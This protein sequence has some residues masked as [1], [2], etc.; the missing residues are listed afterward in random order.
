MNNHYN[1]D[2]KDYASELRTCAISKAEKYLWKAGLS[3]NQMGV[4]FKRQRPIYNFIVD[5][6]S[7][8]IGLIVEVDG[9]SHFT[10]GEYDAYRQKKLEELGYTV[11]RF[12]EGEVMNN[13]PSVDDK[14]R[15]AIYCLKNGD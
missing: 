2:L 10:K 14:I 13:Y 15:H 1:K 5:F 3:R 8:E 11:L 4:K 6:F 9:N 12:N 7:A